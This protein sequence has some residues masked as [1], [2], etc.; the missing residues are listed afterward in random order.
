ML[1]P[2][3]RDGL[4]RPRALADARSTTGRDASKGHPRW[5][6]E[7]ARQQPV[8]S[9]DSPQELEQSAESPQTA[10]QDLPRQVSTA[11]ASRT[12]LQVRAFFS[13]EQRRRRHRGRG[14][15]TPRRRLEPP[16]SA[17]AASWS[18]QAP[19][20]VPRAAAPLPLHAASAPGTTLAD[21][22]PMAIRTDRLS[23]SH[24]NPHL[25]RVTGRV[26]LRGTA[27]VVAARLALAGDRRRLST[28]PCSDRP[29]AGPRAHRGGVWPAR[30]RSAH[31]RR[32][33]CP[34]PT[35]R[36]LPTT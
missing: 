25:P 23:Q 12:S 29:R 34:S 26:A 2:L 36:A 35:T 13:P 1:P 28:E 4:P 21:I 5:P 16:T 15:R 17:G 8:Q 24:P 20:P 7:G 14:S 6:P 32:L 11:L 31:H 22:Q 33:P 10:L 9:A 18:G 19:A 30:G 3:G 27:T